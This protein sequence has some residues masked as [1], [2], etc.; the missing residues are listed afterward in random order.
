M[1]EVSTKELLQFIFRFAIDN[2]AQVSGSHWENLEAFLKRKVEELE[3]DGGTIVSRVA[4]DHAHSAITL[5]HN[6]VSPEMDEKEAERAIREVAARF[7]VQ[8]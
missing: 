2:A 6:S 1:R 5:I 8:F 3:A 7:E 4:I